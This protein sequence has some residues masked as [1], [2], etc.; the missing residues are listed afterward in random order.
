MFRFDLSLLSA[1]ACRSD[2]QDVYPGIVDPR[3]EYVREPKTE[4]RPASKKIASSPARTART[5]S[6]SNCSVN[7]SLNKSIEQ[8]T[9]PTT[10]SGSASSPPGIIVPRSKTRQRR[11]FKKMNKE[12][13][14]S[15]AEA[16]KAKFGNTRRVPNSDSTGKKSAPFSAVGK[17]VSNVGK[18]V[19]KTLRKNMS[20]VTTASFDDT[21]HSKKPSMRLKNF[22]KIHRNKNK[23]LAHEV[24]LSLIEEGEGVEIT[25][26]ASESDDSNVCVASNSSDS[27]SSSDNNS[28]NSNSADSGNRYDI[29]VPTI[30][31]ETSTFATTSLTSGEE[32]DNA[33]IYKDDPDIRKLCSLMDKIRGN[34]NSNHEDDDEDEDEDNSERIG[35]DFDSSSPSQLSSLEFSSSPPPST[36]QDEISSIGDGESQEHFFRA[37]SN[38]SPQEAGGNSFFDLMVF[39]NNEHRVVEYAPD[40]FQQFDSKETETN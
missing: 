8:D 14:P 38:A 2:K 15:A 7:N 16:A 12:S 29:K 35:S 11:P 1:H 24:S 13:S 32:T 33:E 39:V 28:Y 3:F 18:N 26:K 34:S 23:T 10:G 22:Q 9:L 4:R 21:G 20:L 19:L 17:N 36:S 37:G 40:E 6:S 30:I 25:T 5:Q 27:S 31:R